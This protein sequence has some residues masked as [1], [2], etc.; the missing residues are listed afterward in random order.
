MYTEDQTLKKQQREASDRILKILGETAHASDDS[1]GV[2]TN[3]RAELCGNL[4]MSEPIYV[5]GHTYA[6]PGEP[7]SV[8]IQLEYLTVD[9]ATAI[10]E[11][12]ASWRAVQ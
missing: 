4:G 9:Q 3:F 10:A 11:L 12:V 1:R 8:T 6:I 2:R 7:I 5:G